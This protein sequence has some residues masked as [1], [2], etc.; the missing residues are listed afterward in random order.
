MYKTMAEIKLINSL[1]IGDNT[2]FF[3][4][5]Q[6]T[7]TTAANTATKV[8]FIPEKPPFQNGLRL[9]V[10]FTNGFEAGN[11]SIIFSINNSSPD[12][13]NIYEIWYEGNKF[14][15]FSGVQGFYDLIYNSG[16]FYLM[17]ENTMEQTEFTSCLANTLVPIPNDG[18]IFIKAS[19]D[20][21][22]LN[23]IIIATNTG[24]PLQITSYSNYAIIIPSMTMTEVWFG[25]ST[26]GTLGRKLMS[27]GSLE[28][29]KQVQISVPWK[30]KIL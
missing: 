30:Y 17:A 6:G 5:V 24:S 7:C 16:H 22:M 18:V 21:S 10:Y 2:G 20:Y 9:T 28:T 1:T 29:M 27:F 13:Q 12:A 8:V 3:T 11:M 26:S 19:D 15:P 14:V 23:K 25:D 4:N